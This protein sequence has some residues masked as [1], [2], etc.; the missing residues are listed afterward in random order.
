MSMQRKRMLFLFLC[1]APLL[2][3][4]CQKE[5]VP[6]V[7][8]WIGIQIKG[9]QEAEKSFKTVGTGEAKVTWWAGAYTYRGGS[10]RVELI[11]K[12][13]QKKLFTRT[14]IY[15]DTTTGKSEDPRFYWWHSEQKGT[16][17]LK[18][19]QTYTMK[20]KGINLAEPGGGWGMW[21]YRFGEKPQ[22]R[23][24]PRRE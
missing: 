3:S 7:A 18:A 6:E 13:T 10:F 8:E 23:E 12:K 16:F 22:R 17:L 1:V 14:Y 15:G 24:S 9:N 19:G 20:I 4:H 5:K 11:E 2:L 21:L